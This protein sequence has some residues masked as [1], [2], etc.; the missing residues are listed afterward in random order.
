MKKEIVQII[1]APSDLFI[2]YK[3]IDGE[4]DSLNKCLCLALTEDAEGSRGIRPV[5]IDEDGWIDFPDTVKNY[6]GVV[7]G[8][9]VN[10]FK[11]ATHG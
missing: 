5:D 3:G 9:R 10:M 4:P 11:E 8:S 7:W 6:G 2:R 1:P